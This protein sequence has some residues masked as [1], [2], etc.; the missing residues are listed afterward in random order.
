MNITSLYQNKNNFFIL[1]IAVFILFIMIY[2]MA[3]SL[4]MLAYFVWP[5]LLF[6]MFFSGIVYGFV[7]KDKF[8]AALLGI[9]FS[10]VLGLLYISTASLLLDSTRE[11]PEY[12]YLQLSYLF[13]YVSAGILLAI[14]SVFASSNEP[15]LSRRICYYL[16]V[17]V[18]LVAAFY[19]FITQP[20]SLV[21]SF[22][23]L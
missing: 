6:L 19:L 10:A 11:Y 8:K 5:A 1:F 20:S 4:G 13:S 23:G 21:L 15:H 16:A 12:Y 22:F 14:A 2:F 17:G 9:L 18:L 3:G 7:T